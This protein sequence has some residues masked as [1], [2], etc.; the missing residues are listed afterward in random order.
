V[1]GLG[2]IYHNQDRFDAVQYDANVVKPPGTANLNAAQVVVQSQPVRAHPYL[3]GAF[4]PGN[5]ENP[6]PGF[7][8]G[9]GL[10]Q[11]CGFTDTRLAPQKH[12]RPLHDSP[13]QDPVQFNKTAPDTF[14]FLGIY[15]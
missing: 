8:R 15:R 5:I 11:Q 9:R 7:R 3:T 4:L 12:R 14:S 10:E 1:K 6:A 2:R 13:A